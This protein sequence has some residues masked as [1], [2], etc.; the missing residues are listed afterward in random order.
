MIATVVLLGSIALACLAR[1][2]RHAPRGLATGLSAIGVGCCIAGALGVAM[3]T[4]LLAA[5]VEANA[6]AMWLLRAR[7]DDEDDGGGGSGPPDE[8]DPDKPDPSAFDW[9]AF[10]RSRRPLTPA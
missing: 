2:P 6:G 1:P 4:L 3:Q 10:E 7:D 8:P 5:A 9:D